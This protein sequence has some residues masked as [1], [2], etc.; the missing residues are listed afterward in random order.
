MRI[1]ILHGHSERLIKDAQSVRREVFVIGQ[2]VPLERDIDGLDRDPLTTQYVGY[3]VVNHHPDQPICTARVRLI[4]VNPDDTVPFDAKIERVGVV[5]R[6]RSNGIGQDLMSY[7]LR[8]LDT[9]PDVGNIVLESQTAATTFYERLGFTATGDLF[10]D[11]GI[12]HIRM[13]RPTR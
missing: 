6:A 13:I 4:E 7:I 1:E 2:D 9:D 10:E 3:E 12:P 11:A 8:E 5:E